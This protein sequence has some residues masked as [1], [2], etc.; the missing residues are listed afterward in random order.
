M[1]ASVARRFARWTLALAV[2]AGLATLSLPWIASTQ[3]VR[4]R[5][6]QE[7]ATLTGYDVSIATPPE[8]RLWPTFRAVLRDVRF[9]A[10]PAR[11]PVLQAERIEANLLALASLEGRVVFSGLTFERPLLRVGRS[12]GYG[13]L[14]DLPR[15]GRLPP[16]L[17][18]MEGAARG[19]GLTEIR[20]ASIWFNDG[21]VVS[22]DGQREVDLFSSMTGTIGW[23]GAGRPASLNAKAIWRGEQVSIAAFAAQ[24][25]AYFAGEPTPATL[26]LESSPLSLS[27]KGQAVR[28]DQATL[29]GALTVSSPSL[30]RALEWSQADI[31]PGAAVGAV[32]LTARVTGNAGR[33]RLS[34]ATLTLDGNPGTGALELA[35]DGTMRSVSGTLAFDTLDLGTFVGAFGAARPDGDAPL[36]DLAFTDRLNLD[37]RLSAARARG[38]GMDLTE[39]AAT[40]QVK[41]GLAAFDI[42][43]ARAFG[44]VV[45]AGFRVDRAVDGD[46]GELRMTA[47]GLDWAAATRALGWQLPVAAARGTVT[48]QMKGPVGDRSDAARRATGTASASFESGSVQGLSLQALLAHDPAGGFFPLSD[49]SGGTLAFDRAEL[50]A[51]LSNGV[52]RIDQAALTTP[53]AIVRFTGIVPYVGRS[54]ALSADIV[55]RSAAGAPEAPPERRLFIGGSWMS[56]YVSVM[57]GEWDPE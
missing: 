17:G 29:T 53:E 33:L 9:T 46:I 57:T 54:L 38:A 41:R 25:E 48:V 11:P 15:S 8:I 12:P 3:I 50:K 1:P 32:A 55:P 10:D 44:G 31:A 30:R 23:P 49:L 37:L 42:S 34:D 21:R 26:S 14:P 52:A 28:S 7:L 13:Y 6:A 56:P 47:T 20:I 18:L 40:A 27:F 36:F 5:I 45:Q 19:E 51:T 16:L 43:D 2:I 39:V 4:D 24:P 35:S 22:T